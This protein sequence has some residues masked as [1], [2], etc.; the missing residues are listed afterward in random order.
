MIWI[1]RIVPLVILVAVYLGY[2]FYSSA[3]VKKER[4]ELD[5]HAF[6]TAQVW[7]ASAWYRNDSETFLAYRD[8]LLSEA[9]LS[10]EQMTAF[11]A[12]FEDR[13]E[14][15]SYFV[16]MAKK[17]VDSLSRISQPPLRGEEEESGGDT[18][19]DSF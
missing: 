12:V 17:Y 9:G 13:P 1:K 10:S 4:A 8:S 16:S 3:K 6:V 5:H 19:T 15:S 7:V 2:S 11:L 14:R 18:I